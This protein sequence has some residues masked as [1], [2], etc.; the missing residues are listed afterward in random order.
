LAP[1]PSVIIPLCARLY[2]PNFSTP[3]MP[4]LPPN[5]VFLRVG[6]SKISEQRQFVVLMIRRFASFPTDSSPFAPAEKVA[7]SFPSIPIGFSVMLLISVTVVHASLP[8]LGVLWSKYSPPPPFRVSGW[9]F[10][11]SHWGFFESFELRRSELLW[12]TPFSP[13]G[14]SVPTPLPS[15]FLFVPDRPSKNILLLVVFFKRF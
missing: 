5:V 10:P 1:T 6:F 15:A 8:P 4:G 12:F 9:D 7:V 13:F 11:I 2:V 14:M 3:L